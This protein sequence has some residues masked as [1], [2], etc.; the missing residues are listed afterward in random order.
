MKKFL[1]ARPGLMSEA[2]DNQGYTGLAW[3][4]FGVEKGRV[5][6]QPVVEYLKVKKQELANEEESAS[7]A[8]VDSKPAELGLSLIHI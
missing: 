6:C 4:E 2:S 8:A 1:E 3:A 5:E 7:Q